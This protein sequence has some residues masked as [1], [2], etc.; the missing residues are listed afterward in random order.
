MYKGDKNM[1]EMKPFLQ[2]FECFSCSDN[3]Y[4]LLRQV[5]VTAATLKKSKKTLQVNI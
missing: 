3:I 4:Q 2:V 1:A 5:N